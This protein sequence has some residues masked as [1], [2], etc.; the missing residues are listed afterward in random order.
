MEHRSLGRAGLKVSAL[1]LG[2]MTFGESQTW[3]KG[4]TSSDEEAHRVLDVALDRGV[5]LLDTA[6]VYSDGRSEELL[7]EWLGWKRD[8]VL[9]ATKCRFPMGPGVTHAAG[10]NDQGLSRHHIVRSCE[11][12][13]RRLKTTWI[14]LYQV[15]MQDGATPVEETLRALDDLVTSGKVRYV[16]C[17]N[18]TGYRLVES[19]WAA[20]RRDSVRYESVQLQWSLVDRGCEREVIPACRNFGLGVL[21]WGALARGFLSGKYRRG[22]EPPKGSRFE[23]WR[24]TLK[25]Y[26]KDENWRA[27]DAVERIARA[28]GVSP[29]A[30]AHAWLLGKREVSSIIIG[31]RDV[32]QLEDN[33]SCAELRLTAEE[34][35]ELD[36]VSTPDWGYPYSFIAMRE[37]W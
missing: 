8:H 32:K 36:K 29:S 3:M 11:A 24:D 25:H 14:D 7:G 21:V 19:L 9:V 4:V 31:A 34:M 26:D 22:Q 10:P 12:S 28:R 2:C 1:S 27:L 35:S 37:A 13:L 5:T 30:V 33:L 23:S 18:Y 15:H 16:G 17:S 6:D 20:D